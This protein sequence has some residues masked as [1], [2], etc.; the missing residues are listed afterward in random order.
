VLAAEGSLYIAGRDDRHNA[1]R[2]SLAEIVAP[3]DT[4]K[5]IILLDHQPFDLHEAEE[6]G[7][8]FQF[9]GHTHGGQI[10]PITQITD[11][12]YE[13]AHGYIQK[14]QSHIYVSSGIGIWGGKYRI[15]SQSEY[16]VLSL[17]GRE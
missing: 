6:N 3:L 17:R 14:G 5:P 7:I 2:K 1:N 13:C 9:S 15:G 8:D 10:W 16:Y 11:W 4:Q 12:M